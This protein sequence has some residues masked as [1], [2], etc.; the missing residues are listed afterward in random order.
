MGTPLPPNLPGDPCTVCWGPGKPFGDGPTPKVIE[1]RLTS[2]L[3]GELWEDELEQLLLTTHWL[4]Q[5]PSPCFYKIKDAE[6]TWSLSWSAGATIVQVIR[7]LETGTVFAAEIFEECV[8]DIPNHITT[9][10]NVFAYGGFAN[11]TWNPEDL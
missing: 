1:L 10:G 2:I 9:P 7:T 3:P 6:F 11:A 5:Q 4:E 8:V